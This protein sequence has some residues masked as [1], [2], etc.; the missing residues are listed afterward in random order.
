VNNNFG[1]SKMKKIDIILVFG[2]VI[3]FFS[4]A[5]IS[6]F[7]VNSSIDQSD[8]IVFNFIFSNPKIEKIT[9][10][11]TTYD[12]ITI[13]ELQNTN[14][15]RTSCLPVKPVRILLPQGRDLENIEVYVSD[16][17]SLGT[18]FDIELGSRLIHINSL[19]MQ[20]T[21][22]STPVEKN[23]YLE[24]TSLY[25]IIGFHSFRGFSILYLNLYPVQYSS[26]T[27]ELSYY[28]DIKLIIKTKD[29]QV[30]RAFRGLSIDY[31][32]VRYLVDNPSYIDSYLADYAYKPVSTETHDYVIITNSELKNSNGEYT[33][34]DLMNHKAS[35]GLNPTIVTV[36][37]IVSN[38]EYSVDGTWGDA[39]PGNPFYQNDIS[40]NLLLFNDI[41][42][43]IRNFIRYAYM[44][45][46]TNY[47]LLAG[48][49]DVIVED[50]NII[51]LRGLFANESGLPLSNTV[52]EEEDDIPSDVYFAC[53]DGNFNYDMDEHFGESSD[54]NDLEAIDEADLLAEIWVGRACADSEE[55]VSNF[56]MKTLAYEQS[57]YPYLSEILFLGEY[58][59][60][61]FYT[62]WGGDYKD[63]MEH[64]VSS[65]FN[66]NKLYDRD[67]P[68]NN[69][70]PIEEVINAISAS[71]QHIINHDGHGNHY[72]IFKTS[73]DEIRKFTNEKY[74]FLYSHSC[75]T[76]SFDNYNCWH[77]YLEYDCIAEILTCEIPYGAFACILNARYGLGSEDKPEAPSGIYDESFF[78]ALFT[79][80]IRELGRASHYSKED[81]IWRIDENGMR[82]CYYQTNLFGDP[83]LSI[84]NP[85]KVPSKPTIDGP[86][87]G[88]PDVEYDFKFTSVDPDGDDVYYDVQWEETAEI[89]TYGPFPSAEE[90][91]LSHSWSKRGTHTIKGKA[92]D[93][94][95]G[96]SDWATLTVSMSKTKIY[97]PEIMSCLFE[98]LPFLYPLLKYLIEK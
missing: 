85:N 46:S 82:W 17:I 94:Y 92:R 21:I 77:G 52:G 61:N 93:V 76:G 29:S 42:A 72:Y 18:D 51:P 33:L 41:P 26:N 81:N 1:E 40:S 63:Q 32:Y 24:S 73:G 66:L 25:E 30:N 49:A 57:S 44:E 50:D 22:S 88:K 35:K 64:L 45:W 95:F 27:G 60:S 69:W 10:K 23:Q 58:L 89:I 79:E 96:E 6:C 86:R 84:K 78:E 87:R 15:Y 12:R 90:V 28:E 43:K 62:P 34:Q 36:E 16:R 65:K 4:M 56:V 37:E 9:L 7:G 38:P 2:I 83:E 48:D 67:H 8:D 70:N 97:Y 11:N 31:E 47:V 54:R 68:D 20:N 13:K 39:N 59:G 5:T 3:L 55:E 74:F 91:T 14:D 71:P 19:Q 80:N 98:K 75:L 53:L